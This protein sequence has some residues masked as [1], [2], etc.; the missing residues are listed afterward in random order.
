MEVIGTRHAREWIGRFVILITVS[1]SETT[2]CN[3][4]IFWMLLIRNCWLWVL[5]S[6]PMLRG[7]KNRSKQCQSSQDSFT[8]WALVAALISWMAW[9]GGGIVGENVVMTVWVGRIGCVDR[10][11]EMKWGW[12]AVGGCNLPLHK[13]TEMEIFYPG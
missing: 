10:K 1:S 4:P 6:L 2:T 8:H 11:G 13:N 12:D 5:L 9:V 3:I 7:S